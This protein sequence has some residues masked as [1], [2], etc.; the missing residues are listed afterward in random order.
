MSRVADALFWD[1][2][3]VNITMFALFNGCNFTPDL[4]FEESCVRPIKEVHPFKLIDEE[5]VV[6]NRSLFVFDICL[7]SFPENLEAYLRFCF[8]QA[9]S[10]GADFAWFE[11]SAGF[12]FRQMLNPEEAASVYGF[13]AKGN[14]HEFALED[15]RLTS[16]EWQDCIR[17]QRERLK[18]YKK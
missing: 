11:L 5:G 18:I 12:D 8:D 14:E 10:S 16:A 6:G 17:L 9:L 15:N 4:K 13:A 2:V 1:G 7:N 3:Y